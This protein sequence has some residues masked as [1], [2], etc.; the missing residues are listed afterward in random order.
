MQRQERGRFL[1]G[2]DSEVDMRQRAR[3]DQ[4]VD[5]LGHHVATAEV[6]RQRS[7]GLD[8][9]P[10]PSTVVQQ[11]PITTHARGDRVRVVAKDDADVPLDL[12]H[13]EDAGGMERAHVARGLFGPV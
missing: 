10:P 3:L 5:L 6:P 1:V 7:L 2:D 4:G 11:L 9:G 12:Q 13:P 8:Q